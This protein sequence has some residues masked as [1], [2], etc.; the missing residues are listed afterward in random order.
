MFASSGGN[1]LPLERADWSNG[2]FTE[3]LLASIEFNGPRL[4]VGM[5]VVVPGA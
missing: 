5:T 1:E 4:F 3:A 2:A